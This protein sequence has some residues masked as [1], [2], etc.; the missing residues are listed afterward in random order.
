MITNFKIFENNINESIDFNKV[1]YYDIYNDGKL[2]KLNL[3][4]DTYPIKDFLKTLNFKWDDMN[5]CWSLQNTFS[6]NEI[7][8][9]CIPIFKEIENLGYKVSSNNI[10]VD[11]A[12]KLLSK[13]PTGY[14]IFIYPPIP[15]GID[16]KNNISIKV[17]HHYAP[18][19]GFWGNGVKYIKNLLAILGYN[20]INYHYEG[21]TLSED[22]YA[23]VKYLQDKNYNVTIEKK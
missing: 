14:D 16:G 22:L 10:L 7:D 2:L 8:N 18:M 21:Y 3:Y 12:N 11:K 6:E 1:I 17:W 13:Y 15:E 5:R 20:F 4:G 9:I 19:S 23:V